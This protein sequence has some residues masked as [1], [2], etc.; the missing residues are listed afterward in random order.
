MGADVVVAPEFGE[1]SLGD[2][3]NGFHVFMGSAY[4]KDDRKVFAMI[5][6]AFSYVFE[7]VFNYFRVKLAE[8][9]VAKIN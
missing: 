4:D 1:Y 9:A 7:M 8:I 3:P 6:L 2:S 5:H